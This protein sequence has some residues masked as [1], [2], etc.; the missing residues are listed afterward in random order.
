M[1]DSSWIKFATL[2]PPA[3]AEV[4]HCQPNEIDLHTFA[5]TYFLRTWHIV[6]RSVNRKDNRQRV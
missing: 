1:L 6:R 3:T 5:S 4:E 2:I